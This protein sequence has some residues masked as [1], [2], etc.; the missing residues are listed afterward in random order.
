MENTKRTQ[1]NCE[2]ISGVDFLTEELGI[3]SYSRQSV[4]AKIFMVQFHVIRKDDGTGGLSIA[5]VDQILDILQ[6]GMEQASICIAEKGRSYIDNSNY[7]NSN[8]STIFSSVVATNR[9]ADAINLYLFPATSPSFGRADG[10]PSNAL[11]ISG[12]YSFTGVIVHEFGH[13][14]GLFHTHRGTSPEGGGGPAQCP[15]LVNGSNSAIC[16]DYVT[17]TPADLFR[18]NYC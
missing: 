13:C 9:Q 7:Y 11:V 6:L 4:S 10:V 17:D 15:E 5:E 8:P 18:E 14:L 16:G 2:T 1:L 12:S 3:K